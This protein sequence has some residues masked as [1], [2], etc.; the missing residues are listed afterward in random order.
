LARRAP[1]VSEAMR[2]TDLP[3][4]SIAA[5]PKRRQPRGDQAADP[6]IRVRPGAFRRCP[7]CLITLANARLSCPRR[8][9]SSV[10]VRRLGCQIGCHRTSAKRSRRFILSLIGKPRGHSCRAASHSGSHPEP[11]PA[12]P[13]FTSSFVTR[14]KRDTRSAEE[15]PSGF[16]GTRPWTG[17]LCRFPRSICRGLRSGPR[18]VRA[19][20]V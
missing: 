10:A 8:C 16:S 19:H 12:R 2:A 1:L 9:A 17:L 13:T 6:L 11:A 14:S 18:Q 5:P 20:G 3:A 7:P 15:A 4:L